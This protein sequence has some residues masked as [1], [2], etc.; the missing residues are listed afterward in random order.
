MDRVRDTDTQARNVLDRF[1]NQIGWVTDS[2]MRSFELEPHFYDDLRQEAEIRVLT[3]A[4]LLDGHDHSLLFKWVN[5][6]EGDE[7]QVKALLAKQLR[8]RLS[9][10]VSR[11]IERDNGESM[12]SSLDELVEEGEEPI[13][14]AFEDRTVDHINGGSVTD[15]HE[16]YPNL[17]RTILDGFTQQ[18]LADEAHIS[19]QAVGK[20]VR[21]EK[22]QFL[23]HYVTRAGLRVEGDETLADLEEAYT[24][25]VR[26]GR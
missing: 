12:I 4:G 11:Q 1:S 24:H 23:I 5:R 3:F 8:L 21:R 10:Q 17:S 7:K 22:V 18:Q 16:R 2:V 9:Q 14:E 26:S 20:R 6:T 15:M 25:L 19:Q 13:D